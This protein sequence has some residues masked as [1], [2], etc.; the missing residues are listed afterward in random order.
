MWGLNGA[1]GVLGSVL[2]IFIS[3]GWGIGTCLL[4]GAACYLATLPPALSLSRRAI[5]P[6]TT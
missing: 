5:H 3:V 4:A 6:E 2:S 1:F